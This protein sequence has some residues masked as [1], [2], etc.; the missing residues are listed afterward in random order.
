M[1]RYIFSFLMLI[2]WMG[3][4]SCSDSTTD[5]KE[6]ELEV[7]ESVE[8]QAAVGFELNEYFQSSDEI[9]TVTNSGADVQDFDFEGEG[10]FATVKGIAK[11]AARQ[12]Q[13]LDLE[14]IRSQALRKTTLIIPFPV[15]DTTDEN[16]NKHR[17][18]GYLDTDSSLIVYY[19]VIYYFAPIEANGQTFDPKVV[20]DSTAFKAYLSESD[21]VDFSDA[22]VYNL[23]K[24]KEGFALQTVE[25]VI[26]LGDWVNGEPTS[27]KAVSTSTFSSDLDIVKIVNVLDYSAD[28]VG[29]IIRTLYFK[30]GSTSKTTYT[31]N[32][33]NNGTFSR[34]FRDGTTVEGE[35]NDVKDDGHGFYRSLTDFKSHKYLDTIYK[36]ATVDWDSLAQTFA[37]N[38]FRSVRFLT[39]DSSY[40]SIII[41]SDGNTGISTI[42][43]SRH[44][45]ANGQFNVQELD[46]VTL[47]TGWWITRDS[48]YVTVSAEYYGEGSGVFS[49]AVYTNKASYDNGDAAIATAKYNFSPVG[50]GTGIITLADQS[51]IEVSFNENGFGKLRQNGAVKTFNLFRK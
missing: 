45:G 51:T 23:K 12:S 20:Y 30:D 33:D 43:I 22:R 28:G 35:F 32:S 5:T 8:D 4:Y 15:V 9:Q 24:Y 39:G 29:T 31:L 46:D 18:G 50:D 10:S 38:F 40:A 7:S 42:E 25:T 13:N 6:P 44:N 14:M 26:D 2:V 21:S 36:S 49:Y 37:A 27:F 41:A 47:L 1:Q 16:G 48:L 19:D 11:R 34:T 3:L 17:Q